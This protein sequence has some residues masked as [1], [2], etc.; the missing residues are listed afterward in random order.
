MAWALASLV[1]SLSG[2]VL[3]WARTVRTMGQLGICWTGYGVSIIWAWFELG[4]RS[5]GR[6]LSMRICCAGWSQNGHGLGVA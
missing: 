1:M 2:R 3:D 4:M 6:E 5:A